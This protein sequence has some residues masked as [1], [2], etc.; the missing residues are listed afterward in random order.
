MKLLLVLAAALVVCS[1]LA[2]PPQDTPAGQQRF[3]ELY[4]ELV[5]TN[6]TPSSGNCTLAAER[7]A[8]R[9]RSAGIPDRD[10]HPFSTPEYPK[11]GG[12]V[13][14]YPGR[15]PKLKAILFPVCRG[16]REVSTGVGGFAVLTL[17][18]NAKRTTLIRRQSAG[19]E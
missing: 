1:A 18:E 15:D 12:L 9:L 13:A 3:R 17:K 10:L 4:K 8:A 6:T 11:E 16:Q 2:S 7:M 19:I 14:I 5:E